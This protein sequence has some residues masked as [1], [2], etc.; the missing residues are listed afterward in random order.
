[1]GLTG[2]LAV[3]KYSLASSVIGE[4][5]RLIAVGSGFD[6]KQSRSSE[7]IKLIS[8]GLRNTSTYEIS[9]KNKPNFEFKPW[10]GKKEKINGKQNEDDFIT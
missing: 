3:E 6:T 10:L 1:M 8:W 7:S 2:Y 5:R 9:E 4:K